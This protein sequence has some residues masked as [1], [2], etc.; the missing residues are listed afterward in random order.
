MYPFPM[1]LCRPNRAG[2]SLRLPARRNDNEAS[3]FRGGPSFCV[4][5]DEVGDLSTT[6]THECLMSVDGAGKLLTETR[7]N[8]HLERSPAPWLARFMPSYSFGDCVLLVST[9]PDEV[10]VM[11]PAVV[12]EVTGQYVEVMNEYWG[13]RVPS[14]MVAKLLSPGVVY[15]SGQLPPFSFIFMSDPHPIRLP[16]MHVH[17]RERVLDLLVARSTCVDFKAAVQAKLAVADHD[18]RS[19]KEEREDAHR[20]LWDA[21]MVLASDDEYMSGWREELLLAESTKRG[22]VDKDLAKAIERVRNLE[23]PLGGTLLRALGR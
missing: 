15:Q 1:S 8:W 13:R 14:D 17:L 19:S 16:Y 7:P 2:D 3:Q 11:W 22:S 12:T 21:Y 4:T 10:G 20:T 6:V 18:S 9:E 5:V 23:A